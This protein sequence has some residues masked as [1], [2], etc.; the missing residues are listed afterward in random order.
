MTRAMGPTSHCGS[1]PMGSWARQQTVL[2]CDSQQL[3]SPAGM[4]D[5]R[6]GTGRP[7]TSSRCR[8]GARIGRAHLFRY[9][10][11][12][13]LHGILLIMLGC[14]DRRPV[15]ADLVLGLGR[16]ICLS[17]Q[18]V[19][20]RALAV[21]ASG[22]GRCCRQ[23]C[24]CMSMISARL[25]AAAQQTCIAVPPVDERERSWV[26]VPSTKAAEHSL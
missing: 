12:I 13:I 5:S 17:I 21:S 3:H 2:H 4:Q 20:W 18:D 24:S 9:F 7:A 14:T 26:G 10:R 1:M 25:Q 16:R 6:L 11:R 8:L 22:S 15:A 19:F 23:A